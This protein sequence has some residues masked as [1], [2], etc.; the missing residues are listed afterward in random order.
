MESWKDTQQRS[1]KIYRSVDQLVDSWS[2]VCAMTEVLVLK[3]NNAL[4]FRD[5]LQVSHQHDRLA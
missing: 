5:F 3:A 4:F 2:S 1:T